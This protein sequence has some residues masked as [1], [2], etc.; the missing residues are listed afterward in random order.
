MTHRIL[1]RTFAPN[2]VFH[3][4]VKDMLQT[5]YNECTDRRKNKQTEG[6]LNLLMPQKQKLW[7]HKNCVTKVHNHNLYHCH[8]PALICS[9]VASSLTLQFLSKRNCRSRNGCD[10]GSSSSARRMTG[11]TKC[12]QHHS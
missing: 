5:Q 4:Q 12:L 3:L 11:S 1:L 8:L 2:L 10:S 7:G 9:S 6:W